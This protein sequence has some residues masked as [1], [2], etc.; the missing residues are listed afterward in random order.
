MTR[1]PPTAADRVLWAKS[2]SGRTWQD[3]AEAVGCSH[4]ALILWSNGTTALD[5]VKVHLIVAFARETGVNLHWLLTGDGP[6][7]S[8]YKLTEH[9]LV[10]EARHIVAEHPTM[11]DTALRVLRAMEN[12][13]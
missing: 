7:V 4:S 1:E 3:L 11:A 13:S 12:D 8:S 5:N 9:E 10:L 2:Q 6:A